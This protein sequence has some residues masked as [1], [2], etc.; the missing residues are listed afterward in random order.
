M[1]KNTPGFRTDSVA[2]HESFDNFLGIDRIKRNIKK[3]NE[4][5]GLGDTPVPT[6]TG[7]TDSAKIDS[8]ISALAV[9]GLINDQTT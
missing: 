2:E 6:V 8:L 4:R 9:L 1:N 5:V 7:S 3:L